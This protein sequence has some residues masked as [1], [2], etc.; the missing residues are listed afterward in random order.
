MEMETRC[1][2]LLLVQAVVT[3]H[4]PTATLPSY[5]RDLMEGSC[6]EY[7]RKDVNTVSHRS[8]MP[9]SNI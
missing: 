5:P 1:P 9:G 8:K 7:F 2:N 3:A 6:E 4:F